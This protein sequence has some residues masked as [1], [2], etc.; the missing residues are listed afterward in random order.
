MLREARRRETYD[1]LVEEDVVSFLSRHRQAFDLLIAADVLVYIG[2]LAPLLRAA[3]Q[4]MRAGGLLAVTLEADGGDHYTLQRSG[5]FAHSASYLERVAGE[6][7]LRVVSNS[8]AAVRREGGQPVNGIVAL[9]E[10]FSALARAQPS[11]GAA[12]HAISG[13]VTTENA[14]CRRDAGEFPKSTILERSSMLTVQERSSM[15]AS[16]RKTEPWS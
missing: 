6:V 9:L 1:Q 11:Q 13:R 3:A 8:P 10:P 14:R 15:I 7:G 4:A 5:R 2:D 12:T 16:R